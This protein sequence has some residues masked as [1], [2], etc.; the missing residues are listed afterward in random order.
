MKIK[1][2]IAILLVFCFFGTASAQESNSDW[3]AETQSILELL[4]TEGIIEKAI[5][6]FGFRITS[7]Q[8]DG[9]YSRERVFPN[10]S[11]NTLICIVPI[12]F[13]RSIHS[14][15]L[16]IDEAYDSAY[17]QNQ[18]AEQGG[19]VWTDHD[20]SFTGKHRFI[21]SGFASIFYAETG[22]LSTPLFNRDMNVAT[23]TYGTT[24]RS[25]VIKKSKTVYILKKVDKQWQIEET[26]RSVTNW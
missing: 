13:E 12:T 22:R 15:L 20:F 1:L 6:N 11:P 16:T 23:I 14:A 25:S 5:A 3:R 2:I 7:Y 9:D 24:S 21:K 17:Y 18:L 8:F 4:S 19:I 26:I 10:A